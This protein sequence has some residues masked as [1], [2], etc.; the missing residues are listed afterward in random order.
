MVLRAY[1][2]SKASSASAAVVVAAP[3]A[4]VG[5]NTPFNIHRPYT[6]P[7]Y[8]ARAGRLAG[9]PAAAGSLPIASSFRA[10]CGNTANGRVG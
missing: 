9:A 5:A 8:N 7:I 4:A 10:T 1:V 6:T 3:P 2:S